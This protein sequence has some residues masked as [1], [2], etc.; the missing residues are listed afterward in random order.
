MGLMNSDTA[1]KCI[2]RY[3]T[4]LVENALQDMRPIQWKNALQFMRPIQ[5]KNE[6]DPVEK[7]HYKV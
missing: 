3:E 7:M 5:W 4:D 2:T 1:E 6:A